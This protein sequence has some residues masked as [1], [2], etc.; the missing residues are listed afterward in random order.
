MDD[1]II[2]LPC[3]GSLQSLESPLQIGFHYR[4]NRI[5]KL[6]TNHCKY[7]PFSHNQHNS[8]VILIKCQIKISYRNIDMF[9]IIYYKNDFLNYVILKHL[10]LESAVLFLHLQ[11]LHTDLVQCRLQW[12]IISN[13]KLVTSFSSSNTIL[14]HN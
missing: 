2:N 8:L 4:N 3:K 7:L 1:W 11:L 12:N 6:A 13:F 14:P 9:K 10:R 5:L